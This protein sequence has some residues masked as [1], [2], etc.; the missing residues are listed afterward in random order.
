MDK[1]VAIRKKTQ[2]AQASRTMFIWVAGASII[3]GFALVGIIFLIQM[4]MFN[5]RV[6][7]EKET[8]VTTL[9][10]NNNNISQLKLQVRALDVNQNLMDSIVPGSG[11]RAI[12]AILDALPSQ[13]NSLALGASLQ[14]RLLAGVEEIKVDS[15]KVDPVAGVETLDGAVPVV[16]FDSSAPIAI[17]FSFSISGSPTA[18]QQTFANLEKS[19]RTIDITSYKMETLGGSLSL[20]VQGQAFYAPDRVVE[21]KDKVVK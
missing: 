9:K 6:L 20:T 1:D 21:L 3:L 8:T 12:Q 10:E 17:T 5:E 13:P 4:I 15:I 19:I 18:L 14:K 2:I 11:D 16:A 7:K